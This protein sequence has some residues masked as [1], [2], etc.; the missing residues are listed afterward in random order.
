MSKEIFTAY[1]VLAALC[2]MTIGVAFM[3]FPTPTATPLELGN[4]CQGYTIIHQSRGQTEEMDVFSIMNSDLKKA[5]LA[6]ST[7]TAFCAQG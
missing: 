4:R 5:R 1:T 7:L 2:G 6:R 3:A